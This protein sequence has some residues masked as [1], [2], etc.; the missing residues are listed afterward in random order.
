MHAKTNM[1][2]FKIVFSFFLF[3]D[4]LLLLLIIN[5]KP[6]LW[7]VMVKLRE[8]GKFD[9][10]FFFSQTFSNN[11]DENFS[12]F[13]DIV[14]ETFNCGDFWSKKFHHFDDLWSKN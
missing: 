14:Q 9:Y 10:I 1:I 2:V 13:E 12:E 7:L 4:L 8:D 11:F 6:T 3:L 5:G